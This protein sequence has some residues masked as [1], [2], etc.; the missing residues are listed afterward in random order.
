MNSQP[1]TKTYD[2]IAIE[3]DTLI[4]RI[5]PRG[6]DIVYAALPQHRL[7]QGSGPHY[8]LFSDNDTRSYVARSGLQ[9]DE[10]AERITFTPEST[11]YR[12]AEDSNF[13]EVDLTAELN[14]VNITKRLTL[15][16]NSY[17]VEVEYLLTNN[18]ERPVSTR[19]IG[20]L[21][22]DYKPG[23]Y[24]NVAP[25]LGFYQGAAFST[26]DRP[27]ER[28][29]FDDIENRLF[30]GREA[31]GGWVAIIQ[32]HSVSAWV[33]PQK[34]QSLYYATTD[35]RN[36]NVAAFAGPLRTLPPQGEA[37]L[38]ATLYIG[39][40]MKE[41]LDS[42]APNLHFAD[43]VCEKITIEAAIAMAMR[44]M[45]MPRSLSEGDVERHPMASTMIDRAYSLPIKPTE[46]ESKQLVDDFSRIAYS[47]CNQARDK[48][49]LE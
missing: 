24:S 18:S 5:D 31:E 43:N 45:G 30:E 47:V 7:S 22:R 49:L 36:R 6:G 34:Q 41:H 2:L 4:L 13:L 38:S 21:A 32:H 39:P 14:G 25:D 16:R 40:K 44:Q 37:R 46:E 8:V 19:F 11:E 20:Q 10:Q 17:S 3:T 28:V 27:Y 35:D 26:P 15:E 29:G 1:D 48:G 9:I 12:L 42:V 23:T 33:P